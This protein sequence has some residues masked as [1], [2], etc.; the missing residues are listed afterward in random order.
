MET[1]FQSGSEAKPAR[2]AA[3]NFRRFPFLAMTIGLAASLFLPGGIHAQAGADAQYDAD[4]KNFQPL[5]LKPGCWQVRTNISQTGVLDHATAETYRGIMPNATPAQ[6]AKMV[7]D[8]NAQ[9][10]RQEAAAKKGTNKIQTACPLKRDFEGEILGPV[11]NTAGGGCSKTLHSS[12]QDLHLHLQCPAGNRQADFE[13][14]D[15]EDF[16]GTIQLIMRNGKT[17]TT[18]IT[19]AG[20]WISDMGP[21]L[22]SAIATDANGAKPKGPGA[23]AR[24][25]PLRIVAIIDGKQV[26]ARQGMDMI[27]GHNDS[28]GL[29]ELLGRI[30]MQHAIVEDALKLHLDRQSPWKEK[31]IDT[32]RQIYQIHQN[33]AG[34]PNIPPEL[35]AQWQEARGHIL[36]NAYFSRTSTDAERQTL[37]KQKEDQYKIQVRDPDFFGH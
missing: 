22:P 24:V 18:T 26:T 17:T 6:I 19:Y 35:V 14:I 28:S 23:V 32:Q 15:P 13:R 25:D 31:L 30:Y 1:R 5:D 27:R 20:K 36:W 2:L 9:V 29:P 7:A 4:L 12:G 34:D 11:I 37:L 3:R 8:A 16:K 10:D 33:Y 21:H